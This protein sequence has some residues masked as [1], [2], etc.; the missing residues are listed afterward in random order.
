LEKKDDRWYY[1]GVFTAWVN[2]ITYRG[3][4]VNKS[5]Q[6]TKHGN[7]V[8]Y[9]IRTE[10]G[11][12]HAKLYYHKPFFYAKIKKGAVV[13]HPDIVEISEKTYY[14]QFG[15]KLKRIYVKKP[16]SISG[17]KQK[18]WTL[19]IMEDIPGVGSVNDDKTP[20]MPFF[21]KVYENNIEFADRCTLEDDIKYGIE[22]DALDIMSPSQVRPIE[23]AINQYTVTI[24]T[25]VRTF[26]YD[27]KDK[28]ER[29]YV[30][31][32]NY[33]DPTNPV[34][35]IQ[36]LDNNSENIYYFRLTKG[37]PDYHPSDKLKS[38]EKYHKKYSKVSE[39]PFHLEDRIKRLVN[40]RDNFKVYEH[41]FFDERSMFEFWIDFIKQKD[42]DTLCAFNGMGFDFP[43]M[44]GRMMK[45]KIDYNRISPLGYV[46]VQL[47]GTHTDRGYVS[48]TNI[49]IPGRNLIDTMD[50]F[51]L[52]LREKRAR[53]SLNSFTKDY[54]HITKVEHDLIE[55]NKY[56]R[57][58]I[59]YEFFE[60]P[61]K[62]KLYACYDVIIDYYLQI[63]MGIW[64]HYI[65]LIKSCGVQL[66]DI[67]KSRK[68]VRQESL[69]YGKQFNMV[70]EPEEYDGEKFK[71][72]MVITPS[73]IGGMKMAADLDVSAMYPSLI[74]AFNISWDTL[75]L[76]HKIITNKNYKDCMDITEAIELGIPYCS[77]PLKGI[78]FRMDRVGLIPQ[79]IIDNSG[80]RRALRKNIAVLTDIYQQLSGNKVEKPYD[81]KTITSELKRLVPSFN[82]ETDGLFIIKSEIDDWD[83]EQ[84]ILKV[85][86]NSIYGNL[87]KFLAKCVTGG[88]REMMKFTRIIGE[89]CGFPADYSDTDSIIYQT[90][91]DTVKEALDISIKLANKINILYESVFAKKYNCKA[92]PLK[93]KSEEIYNPIIFVANKSKPGEAASK[94]YVKRLVGYMGKILPE[95][96]IKIEHKGIIKPRES[97]PFEYQLGEMLIDSTGSNHSK[98]ETVR[99]VKQFIKEMEI[100]TKD[101]KEHKEL[102]FIAYP[103]N[104]KKELDEYK[105]PTAKRPDKM[106]NLDKNLQGVENTN[107][108][109]YTWSSNF[110]PIGKGDTAFL[111]PIITGSI[112]KEIDVNHYIW[113]L[114]GDNRLHPSFNVNYDMIIERALRKYEPLL[115]AVNIRLSDITDKSKGLW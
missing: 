96:D 65:G 16:K 113:A 99:R 30:D 34:L 45:L 1:Y 62:S 28:I 110:K 71:G 26:L 103:R 115:V 17:Y 37:Y 23:I 85:K 107:L 14:S 70:L 7:I 33:T 91:K 87:P 112:P 78:Y 82:R 94:K 43:Y 72:A 25:E 109:A 90:G 106:R 48:E 73:E 93:I 15:T 66:K 95:A 9:F 68:R 5:Y 98:E 86:N 61:E 3:I 24:D 32:P 102:N 74:I 69:F 84:Y 4:L 22:V 35:S 2:N 56:R 104:V 31:F 27:P 108:Y 52:K 59:D 51:K 10:E 36:N 79:M 83:I 13:N 88:G 89:K 42:Y 53:N 20:V 111:I 54:L 46:I 100:R 39:I 11:R 55:G 19:G 101:G 76:D 67:T 77:M 58:S 18:N 80:G 47:K 75:I 81:E 105:Q 12:E 92:E 40:G 49:R 6:L 114:D 8:H 57:H 64:G 41:I 97:S 60:Q 38:G 21:E 44:F 29:K 63:R 50:L